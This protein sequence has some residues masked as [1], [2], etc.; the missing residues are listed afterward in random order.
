MMVVRILYT[1]VCNIMYVCERRKMVYSMKNFC[2]DK[3]LRC[4]F[5]F[6]SPNTKSFRFFF[7]FLGDGGGGR[8]GPVWMENT[9]LMQHMDIFFSFYFCVAEIVFLKNTEKPRKDRKFFFFSLK[10][11]MFHIFPPPS[12]LFFKL[13]GSAMLFTNV[14]QNA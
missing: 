12:S 10:F 1:C 8:G 7:L 4:F 11:R 13:T 14:E 6:S 9:F 3:R 2:Q 5:F